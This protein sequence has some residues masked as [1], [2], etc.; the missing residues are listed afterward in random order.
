[1]AVDVRATCSLG[2][3]LPAPVVKVHF[4]ASRTAATIVDMSWT[5]SHI[6]SMQLSRR[7]T[8]VF[9]RAGWPTFVR[10]MLQRS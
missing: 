1:M 8:I 9:P 6:H 4:A 5:R 7:T 10:H 3:W 2:T